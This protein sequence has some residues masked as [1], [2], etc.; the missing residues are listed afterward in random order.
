MIKIHTCTLSLQFILNASIARKGIVYCFQF[1][2]ILH[3]TEKCIYAVK[4]LLGTFNA[5]NGQVFITLFCLTTIQIRSKVH[6]IITSCALIAYFMF[7]CSGQIT[8][9]FFSRKGIFPLLM[10]EARATLSTFCM[11]PFHL[12]HVKQF[13]LFTVIYH[14][15]RQTLNNKRINA[16]V[17]HILACV[18]HI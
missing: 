8:Q 15:T 10:T 2:I 1:C 3:G 16:V 11:T 7:V 13:V 9:K 4:C 5:V 18:Q 12:A 6:T 14:N 17:F